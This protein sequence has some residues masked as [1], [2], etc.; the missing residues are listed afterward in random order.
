[1][2]QKQINQHLAEALGGTERSME[3]LRYK[4][5]STASARLLQETIKALD[6]DRKVLIRGENWELEFRPVLRERLRTDNSMFL[7]RP[8]R[9]EGCWV[10][11]DAARNLHCE[12]FVDETN[13]VLDLLTQD[14]PSASAGF[15]LQFS[16]RPFPGHNL[17]L[18]RLREEFQGWWYQVE[19]TEQQGWF[20]PPI[21]AYFQTAPERIY[22]KI[23]P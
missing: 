12:P 17:V 20:G 18:V 9:Y 14:I 5:P 4:T 2:E 15:T 22:A 10:F 3:Q 8:Y 6:E 16:A 11:D 23:R 21:H 1:M 13:A 7:I 19:G